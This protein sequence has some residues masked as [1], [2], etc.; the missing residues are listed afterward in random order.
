[1]VMEILMGL[2]G[3]GSMFLALDMA[4]L[5]V[6]MLWLMVIQIVAGMVGVRTLGR[7]VS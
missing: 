3:G 7:T 2:W 1:M 5:G 4:P 6:Y